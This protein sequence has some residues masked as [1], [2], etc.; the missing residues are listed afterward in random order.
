MRKTKGPDMSYVG[1]ASS[2]PHGAIDRGDPYA[3]EGQSGL[4]KGEELPEDARRRLIENAVLYKRDRDDPAIDARA[5]LDG[6]LPADWKQGDVVP[7]HC[8]A[9][10]PESHYLADFGS[11]QLC[12]CPTRYFMLDVEAYRASMQQ[13]MRKAS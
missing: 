3:L 1:D 2:V 6:R 11:H 4:W 12:T 7:D 5:L 13:P 8:K 9:N 10:H